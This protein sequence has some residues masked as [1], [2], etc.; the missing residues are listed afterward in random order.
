MEQSQSDWVFG[1]SR[2][3]FVDPLLDALV[4][5]SKYYGAPASEDSLSSGLPLVDNRLTLALFP[6]AAERAGLSARLADQSL[7]QIHELLLPCVLL[8]ENHGSCILMSIDHQSGSARI[9]QSESGGGEIEV[10][11]E[12]LNK[13]YSGHLFYIRKKYRFDQRSP[14]VLDTQ[15]GHWFWATFRNATP[16]YRDV[17]VASVLINLFAVASPLFVMNVYDRIV[18]NLAFDSLWVLAIGVAVVFI[19]DFILKHLRSYFIDVAGKKLDLQLSA[20]IFARVMGIRLEARPL[21]VGAFANNLQSF[22]MIREFIT[23]ATL[24]ALIDLPFALIF[25][26]VIW[27]VGGPLVLV[28]LTVMIIL[29]G[30]SLYI[31]KP[32][33]RQIELTSKIA[34]QKQA[35]LVEGLTGIEAVKINGAQSQYQEVWEQAVS[36]MGQHDIQTRK[37]ANGASTLSGFLQ[38]MMTVGTVV[39]G[40]Y[41]VAAGELSMGGIIAAV[42]LGGRAVQPL[43]Q[44]SLLATRFNQ[45]KASMS[46]INQVMEMPVEEEEGKS[47]VSRSK[48][49]GKIEFDKVCFSYPGQQNYALQD[50]SFTIQPGE[51]VALIGGIGA[52]KSSLEKLILGLYQCTKGDVRIDGVNIAQLHPADLRRNVG[53]IMQEN[54]LFFGSIRDN[55]VMGA[56]FTSDENLLRAAQWGGVTAFTNHDPEGLERQVGE[57]GRQLSGGQRQAVAAARAIVMDPP[58]MLLDE[59]SSHLDRK[60]EVKLMNQ[61]KALDRSKT[62]I[63]STH[64]SSL[65]DVVDRIIVLENGRLIADGPKAEVI[66]WLR[67]GVNKQQAKQEAHS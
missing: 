14:D 22:E 15:E 42:M 18:P 19:F 26:L 6:R 20:K 66:N 51:R 58:I 36:K 21:S 54:H 41:L 40:V 50:V 32:L 48:L 64:K 23:S 57:G 60:S 3:Q 35:T 65:L 44:L 34:A 8:L 62:I 25:L 46:L 2:E 10:S 47:Y 39:V 56:R 45:A 7:D 63:L 16:I 27:A 55:I 4:I 5:L 31:Q 59:P 17:I 11:L 13:I 28:P 37:L 52:G 9:L 53:A 38:Q 24:G 29:V 33:A 12:A 1:T 49:Q 61:L 30:Y 67:E 43:A